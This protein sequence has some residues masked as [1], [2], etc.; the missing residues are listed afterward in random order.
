M[1]WR[2]VARFITGAFF[3]VPGLALSLGL[4][5]IQVH[6]ALNQPM[7]AEIEILDFDVSELDEVAVE[8]GSQEIFERVGVPRPYILTRLV[9]TPVVSQGKPVIRITSNEPVPEPFLTFLI[10]LR[11]SQGQLLRE[12]TVLLDPPVFSN[13]LPGGSIE[14]PVVETRAA[15]NVVRITPQPSQ[16]VQASVPTLRSNAPAVN[17]PRAQTS[18][19]SVSPASSSYSAGDRVTVSPGD[20]LWG[21]SEQFVRGTGLS[22]SQMMLAI[23]D[24]NPAAFADNNI[25]NLNSGAILR[26]P[27]QQKASSRSQAEAQS[28]VRN[29][30]KIW[31]KGQQ[32]SDSP[33]VNVDSGA[34]DQA[35]ISDDA[36]SG[37]QSVD[38]KLS[39]LGDQQVAEG[40]SGLDANASAADEL[41]E[42][43]A[44]L[45]ERVTSREQ[46]NK[47]LTDRITSLDEILKKQESIIKLQNEQLAQ[48]QNNAQLANQDPAD[49]AVALQ[50]EVNS[51]NEAANEQLEESRSLLEEAQVDISGTTSIAKAEVEP[52]PDF[53]EPIPEEFLQAEAGL[54]AEDAKT[55][56]ATEDPAEESAKAQISLPD[57]TQPQPASLVDKVLAFA[58][59]Q[60][61]HLM[62]AGGGILVAILAWLGIRRRR[63]NKEEAS[64][65][66]RGMPVFVDDNADDELEDSSIATPDNVDQTLD[67]LEE[68]T[69]ESDKV[70]VDNE[71]TSADNDEVLEEAEVY[72][73]YGL[74]Q[75]AEDLLKQAVKNNPDNVNYQAKLAEI[76]HTENRKDDFVELVSTNEKSLKSN[77]AIWAKVAGLG[78]ALVPAHAL[79]SGGDVSDNVVDISK[80]AESPPAD[81]STSDDVNEELD[82]GALDFSFAEDETEDTAAT[83]EL[84]QDDVDELLSPA[85]PEE[86]PEGQ[87]VALDTGVEDLFLSDDV[88]ETA[89]MDNPGLT[90]DLT[91]NDA[92][93]I[94]IDEQDAMPADNSEMADEATLEFDTSAL[95]D[96][97]ISS[98]DTAE[99][100]DE[101]SL[102]DDFSL[103]TEEIKDDEI[104]LDV[105][106]GAAGN[107]DEETLIFDSSIMSKEELELGEDTAEGQGS[108]I[109]TALFDSSLFEVSEINDAEDFTE[110]EAETELFNADDLSEDS[111]TSPDEDTVSIEQLQENLTAELETLSFDPDDIESQIIEDNGDLAALQ[112][113]EMSKEDFEEDLS[114]QETANLDIGD[115]DT[116]F[117]DIGNLIDDADDMDAPTAIEEVGTKLDLAKAFV[118]MGD[119]DAAKETLTEVL[120]RGDMT[121]IREAKELLDKIT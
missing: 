14:K 69:E 77:P 76:Y 97:L 68:V 47:D 4:G 64:L 70:F 50:E 101:F 27:D 33:A 107:A 31:Q 103:N 48:L 32:I 20:T 80:S 102:D 118:D 87:S 51:L 98:P 115:L 81:D 62:Y 18:E 109:E 45:K 36:D 59:E 74:F 54:Q 43:I 82:D 112:T 66:S 41:R 92:A 116:E 29:Q 83:G 104:D 88:T 34:D 119:Q 52:L 24:V 6:S 94:K 61:Q 96:E 63:S 42:Q 16:P 35:A 28:E 30:W 53:S 5:E 93:E 15:D 46:E 9:F 91:E 111:Q 71:A 106:L 95:E 117:S 60:R 113:A 10:D 100:D 120:E 38:A 13:Q 73:S 78:A 72:I 40:L 44:L 22:V 79:F 65:E 114:D 7:N 99:S 25:N 67:D 84:S 49:A 2:L 90:N 12:Y 75:Q 37:K 39:I 121:Q 86:Q 26:V 17:Q 1:Y 3:L 85:E 108:E 21:I 56:V 57:Q 110:I 19:N 11:W 23:Q 55:A 105:D 8:L 89:S 58:N